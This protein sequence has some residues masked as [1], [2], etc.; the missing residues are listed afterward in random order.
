MIDWVAD[1]IARGAPMLGKPT[2]FEER[3]GTF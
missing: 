2:H 1:W 3:D